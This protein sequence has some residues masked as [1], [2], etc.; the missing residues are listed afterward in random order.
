[1]LDEYLQSY[2][3]KYAAN[4]LKNGFSKGF[5]INYTGP[6]F[7]VYSKNLKSATEHHD[8]LMDKISKEIKLGR[9]MGPF[10][11]LPISNLH[12]SPVGIVPKSDGGWRMIT[13]LSYPSDRGINDFIDPDLCTVQ[14]A[15]FD[16]VVDMIASLGRGALIGKMDVKSAFRLIPIYPGDFDLL[17]FSVDGSYYIDKCLPMGC[18]ISCKIWETFATFLHWLTQFKSG[19]NTSDHYL[20]DFIF[21]GRCG[22]QECGILMSTFSHLAKE[23]G[24][25]LAHDKTSGPTTKLIFLGFEIDTL[26]MII[27]IPEAKVNILR[28]LIESFLGREKVRLQEMQSLVGMLNFFSKAIRSSR[29]FIRRMY[30]AFRGVFK[31]HHHIRLSVGIKSDLKMWLVFLDHFNGVA[32]FPDT[33]WEDSSILQL[34][35]DSAGSGHLGCGGYFRGSWFFLQW[36]AHWNNQDILRDMTFLELI[37]VVLAIELWGIRLQHKKVQFH[38]DNLS[39]VSA[40]NTQ[41]SKSKRVM[42]LVRHLVFRLMMN[43]VIFRAKHIFSLDN[44]VA[45]SLSRKQ[46]YRFKR[47]APEAHTRPDPIP[48]ELVNMI[49]RFK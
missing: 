19:L 9:I 26:E 20:D 24:V 28:N 18:S 39:L 5:E 29:A 2:P 36:P 4:Y 38:V 10:D 11:Q 40:I 23:I 14:Y 32:Y 44:K 46:W 6:R 43:N 1:M 31:P 33:V 21:A 47:L 30:D 42:E 25:P 27:R 45:D 34:F 49:Y 7:H 13:H 3:D 17:G 15:S 8:H 41:S 22:S 37:P 35:T 48:L 16:G 12:I